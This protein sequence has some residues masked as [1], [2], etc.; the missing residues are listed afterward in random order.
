MNNCLCTDARLALLQQQVN[1]IE[2]RLQAVLAQAGIDLR[3][4][5]VVFCS[6]NA[7]Q[8][9]VAGQDMPALTDLVHTANE[10]AL[11]LGYTDTVFI[12]SHPFSA[13]MASDGKDWRGLITY[14]NWANPLAF[15]SRTDLADM[16]QA[17]A[18]KTRSED[19]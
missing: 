3:D 2:R 5:T 11:L 16:R 19:L 18:E 12:E 4:F 8:F 6:G 1:R 7:Y 15:A 10:T 9:T 13:T 17:I 14:T